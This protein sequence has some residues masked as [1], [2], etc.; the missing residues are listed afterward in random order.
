MALVHSQFCAATTFTKF[1]DTC[2]SIE[3]SVTTQC[4]LSILSPQHLATTHLLVLFLQTLILD[5]LHKWNH[6]TCDL[7]WLAFL[8]VYDVLEVYPYCIFYQYIFLHG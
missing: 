6:S 1:Q 5:V 7:L 4:L 8:D 3:N 2:H